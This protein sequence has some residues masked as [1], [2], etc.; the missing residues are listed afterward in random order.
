LGIDSAHSSGDLEVNLV[1]ADGDI[2]ALAS[3]EPGSYHEENSVGPLNLQAYGMIGAANS[4]PTWLEVKGQGGAV[5][6]YSVVNR[7]T[8]WQD[9]P[10]CI[11]LF[12][13]QD[14]LA[15]SSSG[16][17]DPS[18]LLVFPI[19][20]SADPYI[21]DGVFFENGLWYVGGPQFTVTSSLWGRRN[22]LMI[23]RHAIHSVQ[24]AFPGTAPLGIGDISMPDGTT[25][26]GHPNGTHY[27]GTNI[28]VAYYIKP[29]FHGEYGNM[30]YRH[31]CCEAAMTDW[32][33]VEHSNRYSPDYGTCIPGSEST[34]IVDIPRTAM[35]IAKVAGSGH[36]RVIGVEAK[37]EAELDSA[38]TD[39]VSQGLITA[40]EKSAAQAHMATANDHG[41]W[42]WHFNHMHASFEISGSRRSSGFQGPWL[43]GTPEEQEAR[44]RE[45]CPF[46]PDL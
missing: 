29:E 40:A 3:I 18:K 13:T 21:G 25:P 31:I 4:L 44:A 41:S 10:D 26:S 38:L 8:E 22:V 11:Q 34:H 45:F 43:D 36:L 39:L 33:C 27:Y 9:G 5:N 12:G 37:I 46:T 42:I 32:S 7:Q 15:T 35:F 2:R 6:N 1:E 17:H 16:N 28:D 30:C 24:E 14:C 20:H 19:G 23:I